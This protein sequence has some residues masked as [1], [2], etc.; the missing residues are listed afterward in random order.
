MPSGL[1]VLRD[2]QLLAM[3]AVMFD[4]YASE[5]LA[6]VREIFP[7]RLRAMGDEAARAL[8]ASALSRGKAL[9]LRRERNLT[10]FVDLFFALGAPWEAEP[11]A[12]WLREILNDLDRSEDARMWLIYRRLPARCPDAGDRPV[13]P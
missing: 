10:L 1:V 12:A 7:Q 3:G 2:Q 13:A 6:H 5:V 9:G 4:R 11:G 8:I